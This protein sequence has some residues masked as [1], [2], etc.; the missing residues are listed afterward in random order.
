M[1]E[2]LDS[3]GVSAI[4]TAGMDTFDVYQSEHLRYPAPYAALSK[5]SRGRKHP[6]ARNPYRTEY[7]R[8][9]D[10]IIHSTAFRRLQHK[11]Q[12]FA[13]LGE[14][15]DHYRTRLTHTIEV[16]QI[17][18]TI[19]RVLGLNEDLAEAVAL[20]H[21][22]GHTPFGHAGEDVLD[23]LMA[24]HGG[25][26]HNQQ[27]LRVVDFLEKRYPD[28]FG[29]NLT[30]ELREAIIKHETGQKVAIPDEFDPNENPALEGQLVNLADEIAYNGHDIDDG[31]SS[32]LLSLEQLR[33]VGFL[34]GI[35]R[36][37]DA[38]LSEKTPEMIRYALVRYLVDQMVV[39]LGQEISRRLVLCEIHQ[40]ADVR[41]A[42][43]PLVAFSETQQ[44]FNYQLKK[45]LQQHIYEHPRL[46]ALRQKSRAIIT[47]LFDYY[48]RETGAMSDDFRQR[49]PEQPP[50]R[51]AADYIA[52]MT[53]RFAQSE[54]E[55][56]A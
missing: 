36:R 18:R 21:D 52:G 22:L 20:A 42:T 45:F 40:P 24:E 9:R 41:S 25:F 6:I 31:L 50:Y 56:L 3:T 13:N 47:F 43:K 7:Q 10:R 54:Y 32:G 49:H 5:D 51:L 33:E 48:G 46:D 12:V 14:E 44:N 11:T 17:S 55:R 1:A 53:D 26:N 34:A 28:C 27:S 37:I 39:D 29:L 4:M 16:A 38:D 19:A 8:D 15:K 35:F 23:L 2:P 30:Y